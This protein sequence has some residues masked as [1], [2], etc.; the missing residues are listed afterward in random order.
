MRRLPLAVAAVAIA[1]VS[2]IPT[3]LPAVAVTGAP[4]VAYQGDVA[5]D[6]NVQNS[7]V[8]LPLSVRWVHH[9][10]GV[11][12]YAVIADGLVFVPET[13]INAG[14]TKRVYALD[15]T[16]GDVVWSV[17]IDGSFGVFGIA[18]DGGQLFVVDGDGLVRALD[19]ATGEENWAEQMPGQSSF[20]APPTADGGILYVGG[21]GSGGTL[22]AV[23]ESDGS[24]QWS[25]S[26]ANGD[27]SS[28]ALSA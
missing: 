10:F 11:T 13:Q 3:A 8:Q 24:V 6:G 7:G 20:S 28:P 16:T 27:N 25:A 19:G 17:P 9:F 21:A 26:V 23:D 15:A 1:A 2:T 14:F 18:Y 12:G 5:H 22:Y 4:A